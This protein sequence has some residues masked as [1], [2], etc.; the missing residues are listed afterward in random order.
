M[1]EK[2]VYSIVGFVLSLCPLQSP[3][4][5]KN[6][7]LNEGDS[8]TANGGRLKAPDKT[9]SSAYPLL[10]ERDCASSKLFKL[11]F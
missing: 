5:L 8:S 4:L 3:N 6:S 2:S 1:L 7:F 9:N 11:C 10:K